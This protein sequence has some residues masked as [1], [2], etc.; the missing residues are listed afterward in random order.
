MN[1]LAETQTT[2]NKCLADMEASQHRLARQ[3]L[4]LE[5]RQRE[6]DN[7]EVV[8]RQRERD[9]QEAEAAHV[10]AKLDRAAAIKQ[11]VLAP[12]VAPR[13]TNVKVAKWLMDSGRRVK[14][15]PKEPYDANVVKKIRDDGFLL[16]TTDVHPESQCKTTLQ[17][18]RFTD[19]KADIVEMDVA[20]SHYKGNCSGHAN[21]TLVPGDDDWNFFKVTSFGF[22]EQYPM[23]LAILRVMPN[24]KRDKAPVPPSFVMQPPL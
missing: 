4:E 13:L 1:F 12:T 6:V 3:Q 2:F 21:L 10:K 20:K 15:V 14:L 8:V 24:S 23:P 19:G 9:V 11:S 18:V 17:F 16:L 22:Q 5:N 7:F